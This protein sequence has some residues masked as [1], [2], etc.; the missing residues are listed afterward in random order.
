MTFSISDSML[1]RERYKRK[2]RFS[3]LY[4]ACVLAPAA[5][6]ILRKNRKGG[7]VD[8]AFVERLMLAVTEVNGCAACS[9]A[10]TRMALSQGLSPEEIADLLSGDDRHVSPAEAKGILFA[11]HFADTRGLPQR[12]AYEAIVHEYGPQS[13]R[14]ILSAVQVMLAGNIYGIPS[15][16]FYAR[17][18]GRPYAD[19][20]L[21]YE[22]GMQVGGLLVI[23]V[24]LAHA[25]LRALAGKPN[26]RLAPDDR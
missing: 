21:A 5:I 4:S 13:A 3:E 1:F 14:V 17:L 22:L 18:K 23:P 6:A 20:T 24:A 11:Q 25:L 16:A 26:L 19:S 15:S 9:W 10:H 12:A 2:F 7:T 8:T